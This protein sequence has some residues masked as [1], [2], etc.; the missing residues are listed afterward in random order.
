MDFLL[1]A[2]NK[3]ARQEQQQVAAMETLFQGFQDAADVNTPLGSFFTYHPEI[4]RRFSGQ[5]RPT[6]GLGSYF[7]LVESSN[8]ESGNI[9]ITVEGDKWPP[10]DFETIIAF[11]ISNRF[12]T[13]QLILERATSNENLTDSAGN[14]IP[15]IGHLNPVLTSKLLVVN[16]FGIEIFKQLFSKPTNSYSPKNKET[17]N[18]FYM[19]PPYGASALS[20]TTG[21]IPPQFSVKVERGKDE[22]RPFRLVINDAEKFNSIIDPSTLG[23]IDYGA[24]KFQHFLMDHIPH[25]Y[26][27]QLPQLKEPRVQAIFKFQFQAHYAVIDSDKKEFQKS[28]MLLSQ[29][30]PGGKI[31]SFNDLRLGLHNIM[32]TFKQISKQGECW[33]K[34]FRPLLDQIDSTDHDAICQY[35][36]ALV[37]KHVDMALVKLSAELASADNEKQMQSSSATVYNKLRKSLTIN[38]EA[39][40]IE[41]ERMRSQQ[42]I[43][44]SERCRQLENNATSQPARGGGDGGAGRKRGG[45]GN[46]Q[47]R[48]QQQ[49]QGGNDRDPKR[50]KPRGSD[51]DANPGG[52]RIIHPGRKKYCLS[53]ILHMLGKYKLNKCTHKNCNYDH[54]APHKPLSRE[55]AD[56]FKHSIGFYKGQFNKID[57]LAAVD[58]ITV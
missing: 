33:D 26:F 38:Y 16:G 29:F 5:D 57:L 15:T 49:Q 20:S 2:A 21:S 10:N 8:L 47:G 11:R 7:D 54:T 12:E 18:P 51:D 1:E 14:E 28:Y 44:L 19:H 13:G 52:D 46:Q 27:E 42:L 45:G 6:D 3:H 58:T 50:H 22:T 9:V 40:K 25:H 23:Y 36:L 24:P 48:D 34:I 39:F 17:S 37:S 53:T 56:A 30:I 31:K 4:I 43:T 41:A 55:D 32:N 35:D